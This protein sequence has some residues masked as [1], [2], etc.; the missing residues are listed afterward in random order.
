MQQKGAGKHPSEAHSCT[1]L[2]GIGFRDSQK[3]HQ[4]FQSRVIQATEKQRLGD[5]NTS[6]LVQLQIICF[7]KTH[8]LALIQDFLSILSFFLL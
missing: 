3:E 5:T 2:E 7:R 4:M 1:S 8:S 6:D